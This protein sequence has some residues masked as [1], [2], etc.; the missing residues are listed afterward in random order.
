VPNQDLEDRMT[1]HARIRRARAP[2]RLLGAGFLM[3][4]ATVASANPPASDWRATI[5]SFAQQHFRHPAWG[6]SHSVRDYALATALAR[7]DGVV[8]DDDVLYAAAM[9]HD[10]AAF[11]PWDREQEGIDHADEGA[12]VV[13]TIVAGSGFPMDKLPAL[14]GAILTHMF[15]RRPEGAEACYLHDA[16]ALDWL[17][18]VGVARIFSLV[19]PNG[20]DPDA[21][22]AVKML[23]ENLA[24]VP[25]GVLTPA[26]R[27]RLPALQAELRGYLEA[28]RRETDELR[29]L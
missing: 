28:L 25:A 3:L 7:E 26:A 2:A 5:R 16:D 21:P 29:T 9:L 17:G 8:L 4:A 6:Y 15:D 22:K 13:E 23:D 12:R 20:G 14:R 10:I 1:A 19:A 27:K 11:A 18:A 24:A